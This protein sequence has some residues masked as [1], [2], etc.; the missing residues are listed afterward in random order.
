M[1]TLYLRLDDQAHTED[2]TSIDFRVAELRTL[3]DFMHGPDLQGRY[4]DLK[5][6][7]RIV[8]QANRRR[9]PWVHD[10]FDDGLIVRP[11]SFLREVDVH[12]DHSLVSVPQPYARRRRFRACYNGQPR[13]RGGFSTQGY[14]ALP[15]RWTRALRP[16]VGRPLA[17]DFYPGQCRDLMLVKG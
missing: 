11:A 16:F 15:T 2:M 10:L 6:F 4:D 12:W 9:N 8:S 5:Q 13:V 3:A 14:V 1:I 17:V 7:L